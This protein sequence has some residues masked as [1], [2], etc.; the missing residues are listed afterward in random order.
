MTRNNKSNIVISGV[1]P[2]G[3]SDHY[4]V[5][6]FRKFRGSVKKEHKNISTRSLK[7]INK[8]EFLNDLLLV[9]WKGI[10]FKT[11][12]NDTIVKQGSQIFSLILEY[13]APMRNKRV[14][15]KFSPWLTKEFQTLS[16]THDRLH[17]Q[18]VRSNSEILMQAYR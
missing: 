10:V 6:C 8:T 1:H 3:L 7:N 18:A 11:A 2:L 5:Y 15:E 17:K 9:D 12:G 13:H 14:S 16:A 4:L